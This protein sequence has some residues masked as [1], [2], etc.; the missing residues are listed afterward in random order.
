[1]KKHFKRLER[2]Q[3]RN[4]SGIEEEFGMTIQDK[5]SGN[6]GPALAYVERPEISETYADYLETVVFDGASIRM[7]FVV[8]RF[9]RRNLQGTPS[10]RRVTAARLVLP[11]HGAAESCLAIELA[12]CDTPG[13]RHCGRPH[14]DPVA[15]RRKLVV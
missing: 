2:A 4:L 8:N 12:A 15:R 3:D 5:P 10:G 13:T 9:D 11:M 7:E 14:A 1:L 6:P